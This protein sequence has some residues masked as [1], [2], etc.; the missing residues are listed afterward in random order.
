M[1]RHQTLVLATRESQS[2]S[3]PTL[4]KGVKTACLRGRLFSGNIT[5]QHE[6]MKTGE[7]PELLNVSRHFARDSKYL[8]NM[9][10]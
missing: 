8:R 2:L 10:T 1:G 7:F 6:D 3:L 4:R 5:N 9:K